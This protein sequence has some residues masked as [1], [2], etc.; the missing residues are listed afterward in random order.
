MGVIREVIPLPHGDL[1]I[2]F[3]LIYESLDELCADNRE[4]AYYR[5]SEIRMNYLPV[6]GDEY[7]AED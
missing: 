1:L 5:L 7:A 6:D 3:A 2:G 4:M